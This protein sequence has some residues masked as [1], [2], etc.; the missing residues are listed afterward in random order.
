MFPITSIAQVI[1]LEQQA[2]QDGITQMQMMD[3]AGHALYE[4]LVSFS[5]NHGVARGPVVVLAGPG[6]NGGD[7]LIAARYLHD[8]GERVS[9]YL[10]DRQIEGD[11]LVTE[12]KERDVTIV[13]V[14]ND[15]DQIVL[16]RWLRLAAWCIDALLGTGTNRPIVGSLARI[17]DTVHSQRNGLLHICAADC[18]SGLNC[19]TG[20]MDPRTLAADLTVMFGVAKR[21]IYGPRAFLAC[22]SIA[23]GEI[24]LS[25][26]RM[27]D[28]PVQGMQ[29]EDLPSLLPPRAD[30]GHKG[31]FGKVLFVGGCKRYPGAAV[32]SVMAAA[33]TG[34]GLVTAAVPSNIQT[35]MVSAIPDVTFLP[36]AHKGGTL[37][38]NALELLSRE[39]SAYDAVLLGC[40]LS[41]TK[42][43]IAF[44]GEFLNVYRRQG[45]MKG[46]PLVLDADALNCL[47]HIADW[48]SLLPAATVLTPHLA[49]MGRLCG[50]DVTNMLDADWDLVSQKAADWQCT[51]VLKGYRIL[52]GTPD[53][54]I[55][56]L[57]QPNSALSTAGTGDVLSG[58]MV[59]F[60][61]Q[62]LA[63]SQASRAAALV[64]SQAGLACANIIGPASTLA[65]DVLAQV[66]GVIKQ[67][68]IQKRS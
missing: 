32:F 29:A 11:P 7:G 52:I 39:W 51:V 27:E 55:Y 68:Y 24:G 46:V 63:P 13:S 47:A 30:W 40:G 18:P 38:P 49:E 37:V 2:M 41:C 57:H 1:E 25:E 17:L 36:L 58:L 61:A 66:A 9:V 28:L 4:R 35:G 50:Q 5:S 53:R 12:L 67:A 34:A 62:G 8:A 56:V 42:A 3:L 6:N 21:G 43:T 33:R 44:V 65:S 48:P 20:A 23:V 14:Q 26:S 15:T 54:R 45:K 31:T 10:W 19:D 16:R 64:H 59:G 60:L 22:G